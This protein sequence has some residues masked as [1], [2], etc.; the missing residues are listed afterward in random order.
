MEDLW[1]TRTKPTPLLLAKLEKRVTM[2]RSRLDHA[3]KAWTLEENI[4]IFL[5]RYG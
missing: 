2:H 4:H 1:K 5:E 3:Q